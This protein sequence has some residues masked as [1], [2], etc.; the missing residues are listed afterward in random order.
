M[1]LSNNFLLIIG[2][3]PLILLTGLNK[4]SKFIDIFQIN[5]KI[6]L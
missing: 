3:T 5:F 2:P 6:E 4:S 1:P